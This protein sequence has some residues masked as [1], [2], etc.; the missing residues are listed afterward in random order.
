MPTFASRILETQLEHCIVPVALYGL[1]KRDFD[2][3]T[4][5]Y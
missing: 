5:I 4:Y 3:H 1:C 2:T